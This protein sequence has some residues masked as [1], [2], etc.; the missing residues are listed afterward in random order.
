MGNI[1]QNPRNWTQVRGKMPQVANGNPASQQGGFAASLGVESL[2][3]APQ[4]PSGSV[5]G[6]PREACDRRPLN[7]TRSQ[8]LSF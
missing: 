8:W 6:W 5:T 3:R 4:T 2:P 7:R 1:D